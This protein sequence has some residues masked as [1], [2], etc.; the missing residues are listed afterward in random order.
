MSNEYKNFTNSDKI[1][2]AFLLLSLSLFTDTLLIISDLV[3]NI[4]VNDYQPILKSTKYI[5]IITAPTAYLLLSSATSNKALKNILKITACAILLKEII[6]QYSLTGLNETFTALKSILLVLPGLINMLVISYLWGAVK[7]NQKLTKN[8][9]TKINSYIAFIYIIQPA[10]YK[11][12]IP[13]L[14]NSLETYNIINLSI[15]VINIIL[16]YTVITPAIFC[17][18][19]SDIPQKEQYRFWNR[20][21]LWWLLGI[22]LSGIIGITTL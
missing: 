17:A 4:A 15:K 6:W 2:V 13:L 19:P 12:I 1:L 9:A 20:Y 8:S 16:L 5:L 3:L 14:H 11:L 22:L 21:H 18:E 10:I 7:R